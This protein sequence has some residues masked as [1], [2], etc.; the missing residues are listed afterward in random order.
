MAQSTLTRRRAMASTAWV[1][2]LPWALFA[3]VVGL[4]GWA[5]LDAKTTRSRTSS[6]CSA[7]ELDHRVLEH[8]ATASGFEMGIRVKGT[9]ELAPSW[10]PR[11]IRWSRRSNRPEAELLEQQSPHRQIDPVLRHPSLTDERARPPALH[12]RLHQ[13]GH[14]QPVEL[15]HP[16]EWCQ[17]LDFPRHR[18]ASVGRDTRRR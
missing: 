12:M 4:R 13:T 14:S 7:G 1:C 8:R 10:F 16:F 5:A 9:A 18:R 2:R 11:P 3:V 15:F 17:V 6:S